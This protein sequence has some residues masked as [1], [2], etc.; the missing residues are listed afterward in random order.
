MKAERLIEMMI[1]EQYKNMTC[2]EF[3]KI[4]NET[5]LVVDEKFAKARL[6]ALDTELEERMA[7][8]EEDEHYA[9]YSEP[10]DQEYEKAS[11]NAG[12]VI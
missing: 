7:K 3:G 12:E 5:Q 10:S 2:G 8:I 6:T 4:Y 1:S 9:D 11:S